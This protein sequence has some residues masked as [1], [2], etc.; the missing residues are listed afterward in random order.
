MSLN[1]VLHSMA[2]A[3]GMN[4]SHDIHDEIDAAVPE[5]DEPKD[6]EKGEEE[7]TDA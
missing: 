1:S 2:H 5:K 7:S 3:I 6:E 4:Q